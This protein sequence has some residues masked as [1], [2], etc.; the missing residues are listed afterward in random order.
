MLFAANPHNHLTTK[1]QEL[2][3][4]FPDVPIKYIGIPS[5]ANGNLFDWQNEPLWK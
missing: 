4:K 5:D 2:F 1:S 3:N